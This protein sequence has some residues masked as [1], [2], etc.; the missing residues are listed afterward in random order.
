ML[1]PNLH[2]RIFH[3]VTVSCAEFLVKLHISVQLCARVVVVNNNARE[4]SFIGNAS[5]FPFKQYNYFKLR[6][7][8][9]TCLYM[10][11]ELD[12][13]GS[14]P[15]IGKRFF[16]TSQQ[17]HRLCDPPSLLLGGKAAGREADYS[18]PSNTEVKNGRAI[19]PPPTRLHGVVLNYLSRGTNLSWICSYVL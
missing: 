2:T 8:W 10:L 1:I 11:Y 17:P 9:C 15:S 7:K 6:N 5:L 4:W 12:G 18:P 14:I 16:A 13:R 3:R 19:P